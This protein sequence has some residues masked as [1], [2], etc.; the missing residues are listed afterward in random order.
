M[1]EDALA[2]RLQRGLHEMEE[3]MALLVQRVSGTHHGSYFFPDIGGVG[4][5]YNAYVWKGGID[6]EAGMLR[7][8]MGLGTRAVN[9]VEGD[10]PRIV[11]LDD[12][13]AKPL[14]E[15]ED[16]RRFS[17]H[18]IDLL[19]IDENELQTVPWRT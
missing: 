12:P 7:L 13:G 15:M 6:P 3:Q 17:Q 4:F 18:D 10:Y 8:A 19:N 5:S 2:Y 16:M 9:R 11:A 14:T 1:N